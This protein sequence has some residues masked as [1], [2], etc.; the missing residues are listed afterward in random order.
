MKRQLPCDVIL[1]SQLGG[2]STCDTHPR[3][4]SFSNPVPAASGI[5]RGKSSEW[6]RE[7]SLHALMCAWSQ[8]GLKDQRQ[9]W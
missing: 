5:G 7:T 3:V 9:L 8:P 1:A 6:L 4:P 2:D